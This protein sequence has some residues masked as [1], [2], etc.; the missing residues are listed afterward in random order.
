MDHHDWMD[1]Y[2]KMKIKLNGNEK[3]VH[4]PLRFFTQLRDSEKKKVITPLHRK[5]VEE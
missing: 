3:S 4:T 1:N 5:V 2:K